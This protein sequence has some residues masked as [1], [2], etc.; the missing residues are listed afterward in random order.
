MENTRR[1]LF[2]TCSEFAI[3]KMNWKATSCSLTPTTP[4]TH[5]IPSRGNRTTILR[6]N[7]LKTHKYTHAARIELTIFDTV[8]RKVNNVKLDFFW[9]PAYFVFSIHIAFKVADSIIHS[10]AYI[11]S[12]VR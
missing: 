2:V 9:R 11:I 3:A 4:N 5:M 6:S 1:K 12:D 8:T 10:T 7:A